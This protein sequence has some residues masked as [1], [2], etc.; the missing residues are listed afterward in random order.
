MEEYINLNHM[1]VVNDDQTAGLQYYWPHHA[2]VKPSSTTT[3]LRVVF[4]ASNKSQSGISLNDTLAVGP[5]V[6]QDLISIILRFQ[7]HQVASS[8]NYGRYLQNVSAD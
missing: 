4:N 6:Q 5:V 1:Q 8:G 3:K 7:K 2:V